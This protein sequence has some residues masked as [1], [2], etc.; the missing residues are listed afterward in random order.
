MWRTSGSPSH[1]SVTWQSSVSRGFYRVSFCL[2]SLRHV[3]GR[4]SP[5][6]HWTP[7]LTDHMLSSFT[8]SPTTLFFFFFL[9]N[10]TTV[11]STLK[12]KAFW[13]IQT[14][15]LPSDGLSLSQDRNLLN[16]CLLGWNSHVKIIWTIRTVC[17]AT[18]KMR[19]LG[20]VKVWT[21]NCEIWNANDYSNDQY[22]NLHAES[23]RERESILISY[24]KQ[25][26]FIICWC[27]RSECILILQL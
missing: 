23:M 17:A 6:S 16:L 3:D 24:V 18:V 21:W 4:G 10:F 7:K 15:I 1:F 13:I 19:T 2:R 22:I 12:I 25:K 14:L 8:A 9:N 20:A 11:N 26:Y 5:R 27:F